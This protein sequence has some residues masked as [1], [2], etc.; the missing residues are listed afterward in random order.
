MAGLLILPFQGVEEHEGSTRVRWEPRRAPGSSPSKRR[1]GPAPPLAGSPQYLVGEECC[2]RWWAARTPCHTRSRCRADCPVLHHVVLQLA[3][4]LEGL[5]AFG[6]V[7]LDGAPVRGEVPL[8]S[9]ASVGKSRPHYADVFPRWRAWP[10][11]P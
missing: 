2:L 5:V 8:L 10:R 1:A 6:A 11:E 9:C 7:V 3:G 4:V